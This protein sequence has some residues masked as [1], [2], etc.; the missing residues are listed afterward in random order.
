MGGDTSAVKKK[1]DLNPMADK[2]EWKTPSMESEG[3]GDGHQYGRKPRTPEPIPIAGNSPSEEEM[4]HWTP[5]GIEPTDYDDDDTAHKLHAGCTT[6]A[7]Y[8]SADTVLYHCNGL[9][10]CPSLGPLLKLATSAAQCRF[11]QCVGCCIL[12]RGVSFWSLGHV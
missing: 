5:T 7:S 10:L 12:L 6:F 2:S 8:F 4:V 3:K 9:P 1:H 11:W